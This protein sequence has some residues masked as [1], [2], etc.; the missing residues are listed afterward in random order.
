AKA[1]A[2]AAK[3]PELQI[4]LAWEANDWKRLAEGAPDGA[5]GDQ[6]DRGAKAAYHRLAGNKARYD[7]L[8][9]DLRKDL[10]G[11]EGDDSAAYALA[12]ALLLNG[13]GAE[14]I[15]VLKGRNKRGSDLVFD[16]LCAQ[17]KFKEAFA[18]YDAA[19][20]ELESD[21]QAEFERR[22]LALR[23]GKILAALGDRD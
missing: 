20:K 19:M 23:R 17:L 15:D 18:Y 10:M 8:I 21:P 4:E 9:A 22:E 12:C 16:L 7:E 13:Q 11:V 5:N 14:A 6:E 3:N 2:D 1:A